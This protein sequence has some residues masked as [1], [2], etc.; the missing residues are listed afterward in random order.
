MPLSA[1]TASPYS[2]S[3]GAS[4][5]VKI[6]ATNIK[7][8]SIESTFGS[9]ATVITSPDAP[10]NLAEDTSQR[11]S[12]TLG[13]TWNAGTSNGGS[14]VLDYRISIAQQGGSFDFQ[15]TTTSTDYLATGLTSGTTYEFKIE[16]R[17]QYGYSTYSDTLSLLSAYIPEI[18]TSI[19]T[20]ID[21]TSVKV[22]W[23]LPSDNGSPIT[24]YKVY[25]R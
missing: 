1:L 16:A 8:T 14:V 15:T 21:G 25:I 19:T 5:A 4:I 12:T 2:L 7:G 18:P 13:V 24:Q 3:L 17:N 10:V 9:G 23:S 11:T 6:T 22:S 20:V